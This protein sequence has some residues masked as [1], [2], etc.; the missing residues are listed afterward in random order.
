[1]K[2]RRERWRA[3]IDIYLKKERH[4]Y[5]QT[6]SIEDRKIKPIEIEFFDRG[7]DGGGRGK[8][9]PLYFQKWYIRS[10]T[11]AIKYCGTMTVP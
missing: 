7:R 6:R 1:M 4:N 10:W 11:G 9:L 3:L 8:T 2:E 5:I